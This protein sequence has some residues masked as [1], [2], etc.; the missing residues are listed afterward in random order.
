M[1]CGLVVGNPEISES[2]NQP[3]MSQNQES[4]GLEMIFFLFAQIGIRIKKPSEASSSHFASLH[5]IAF[6]KKQV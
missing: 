2:G 3:G 6:S 4:R 1:M 5:L